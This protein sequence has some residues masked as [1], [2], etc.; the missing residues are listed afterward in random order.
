MIPISGGEAATAFFGRGCGRAVSEEGAVAEKTFRTPEVG[1]C[2][3]CAEETGLTHLTGD[4]Q[5]KLK[6]DRR[7]VSVVKAPGLGDGLTDHERRWSVP[8][9]T[10]PRWLSAD[11]TTSGVRSL[12]LAGWR[13]QC[14]SSFPA[15]G[16]WRELWG[17]RP[18]PQAA[19]WLALLVGQ[20]VDSSA[21]RRDEGVPRGP[22]GPPHTI[23][24]AGITPKL[25]DIGVESLRQ[26]F[27][28][29][30]RELGQRCY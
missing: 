23:G 27:G 30:L 21:R 1:G 9:R 4:R 19:P 6:W 15:A 8:P 11:S 24:R 10:W 3:P 20:A 2:F 22:G 5:R 17:G 7:S 12:G 16:H 13:T 18:R 25:N 26:D 28:G 29:W 14:H